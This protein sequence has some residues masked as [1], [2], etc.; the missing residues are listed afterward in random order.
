MSDTGE[1][2]KK[3]YNE[4]CAVLESIIALNR[5]LIVDH[6]ICD[7]QSVVEMKCV[8]LDYDLVDDDLDY[9]RQEYSK[10]L[11][12]IT[13]SLLDALKG[14]LV[15]GVSSKISLTS[16]HMWMRDKVTL[17]D[18][19]DIDYIEEDGLKYF[20]EAHTQYKKVLA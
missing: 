19:H 18:R 16:H 2:R 20:S 5:E 3:S 10:L 11:T 9:D 13:N 8:V 6:E 1:M 15:S 17:T 7:N 4:G 14:L 12:G